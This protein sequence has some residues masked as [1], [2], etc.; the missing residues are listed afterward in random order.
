M[1]P[2]IKKEV[3]PTGFALYKKEARQKC[4]AKKKLLDNEAYLASCRTAQAKQKAK[5]PE[6]YLARARARHAN[7]KSPKKAL[8]LELAYKGCV[9]CGYNANTAAIEFHHRN[10]VEKLFAVNI[11]SV[12]K[13]DITLEMFKNE[14]AKCDILCAN[15]HRE[16]HHPQCNN[17]GEV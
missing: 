11:T 16:L 1:Q 13:K 12:H 7:T 14:I 17:K 9:Q 4:I 15:C 3:D 10:P 6:A 8:L 5:D 2:Y